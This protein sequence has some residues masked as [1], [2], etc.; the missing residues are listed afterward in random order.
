M[1]VG[2]SVFSFSHWLHRLLRPSFDAPSAISVLRQFGAS[3]AAMTR[4][5]SEGEGD[6]TK[7]AGENT[8]STEDTASVYTQIAARELL[9]SMES[10]VLGA[11]SKQ[12][13]LVPQIFWVAVAVL[14]MPLQLVGFRLLALRVL[15]AF[16]ARFPLGEV[17]T[18][19]I[20]NI[21]GG[22]VNVK[23]WCVAK[24]PT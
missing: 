20:Y 24:I 16:T 1:A 22:C 10:M 7:R 11:C 19:C 17:S 13:V 8:G 3:A 12:L 6:E 4:I 21:V 18:A 5:S 23:V 9:I 14:R 15:N 2:S